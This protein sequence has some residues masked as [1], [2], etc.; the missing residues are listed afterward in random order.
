MMPLLR[1]ATT[2]R[3]Y[4]SPTIRRAKDLL[5]I[6]ADAVARYLV[7]Q[8]SR[9]VA[10]IGQWA[11][12]ILQ[13]IVME[14]PCFV[15][16]GHEIA[17]LVTIRSPRLD[18]FASTDHAIVSAHVDSDGFSEMPV[19]SRYA[20]A[21]RVERAEP[22]LADSEVFADGEHSFTDRIP[23]GQRGRPQRSRLGGL[24]LLFRR[25]LFLLGSG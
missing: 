5:P 7:F 8:S 10:V 16:D 6:S 11:M 9:Q 21:R 3:E 2:R 23:V 15:V 12:L 19:E 14:R 24:L 1:E 13:L 18:S 4:F 22:G 20:Q 17:V 25:S